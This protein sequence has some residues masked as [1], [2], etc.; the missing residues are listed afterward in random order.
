MLGIKR[1]HVF[2]PVIWKEINEKLVY[3]KLPNIKKTWLQ[4][5]S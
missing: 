5:F 4:E 2:F 3:K 1:R